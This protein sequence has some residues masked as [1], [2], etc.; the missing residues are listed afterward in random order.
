VLSIVPDSEQVRQVMLGEEGVLAAARPGSIVI[1][2]STIDPAVTRRVGAAAKKCGVRM[3]DCPVCRSSEHA[4]E[5]TLMMLVGGERGDFE[6]CLPLLRT[7]GDTFHHCGAL[8]SGATA[9]VINN[10]LVQGICLAACECLTLGV[11]AGL[12]LEQMLE[13]FSGTAAANRVIDTVYPSSAF[14]G[15]F[16]LGF[17]LD[18]AHKDVGHALRL[19]GRLGVPMSAAAL[20]H[21]WQAIAR[22]QGK[23][24]M[25]HSALL[26]VFEEIAGVPVRL[27]EGTG[28]GD[29][30]TDGRTAP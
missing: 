13:I 10:T 3:L 11:R 24:R 26:T 7:M 12:G 14:V 25:D 5:G 20:V 4:V 17:A 23:G 28:E 22:G 1:E 6:E 15:D 27:R 19:A 29:A 18:W 21:Q 16:G 8:G 9:K 2:M 30:G